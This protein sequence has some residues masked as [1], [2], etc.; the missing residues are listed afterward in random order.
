MSQDV[1]DFAAVMEVIV[2]S[3]GALSVIALASWRIF[4]RNSQPVVLPQPRYDDQLAQL[5]H[6]VDA[7][8]LEIERIAEAQRFSTRL[9]SEGT[10]SQEITELR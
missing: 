4:R 1:A 5:Q 8:A 7:M 10:R 6:S 9:L 2:A 3:V